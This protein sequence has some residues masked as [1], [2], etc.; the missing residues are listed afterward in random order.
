MVM[1]IRN[2]NGFTLI[3]LLVAIALIMVVMVPAMAFLL[4]SVKGSQLEQ[5][6]IEVTESVRDSLRDISDAV[7]FSAAE[8]V[9][10][11]YVMDGTNSR[12]AIAVGN[13][14]FCKVGDELLLKTYTGATEIS[15]IVMADR[16]TEFVVIG[17]GTDAKPKS[18]EVT[19]AV[20]RAKVKKHSVTTTIYIRGR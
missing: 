1:K 7:R 15:S 14:I 19:L 18:I 3:E 13:K 12:K 17:N 4:N 9:S 11:K 2:R 8:Q 16:V 6:R 5:A 20:E 10:I